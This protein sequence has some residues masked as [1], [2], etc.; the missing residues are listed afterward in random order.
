MGLYLIRTDNRMKRGKIRNT[1]R[2][3]TKT[4]VGRR[5][6]Q[7]VIGK[8]SLGS[9]YPIVHLYEAGASGIVTSLLSRKGTI[10]I[11]LIFARSPKVLD[12]PF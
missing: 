3:E 4:T 12:P 11:V 1:H 7:S 6:C 9:T 8:V 5:W 10:T 2:P